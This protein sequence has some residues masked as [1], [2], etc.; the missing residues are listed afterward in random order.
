[1]NLIISQEGSIHKDIFIIYTVIEKNRKKAQ[2]AS[3]I[4]E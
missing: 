1:M 4:T 2:I 3:D